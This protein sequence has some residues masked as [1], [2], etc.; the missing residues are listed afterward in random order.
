[1]GLLSIL[2]HLLIIAMQFGMQLQESMFLLSKY[3]FQMSMHRE[4]FRH[5]SVTAPVSAGQIVGL[6]VQGYELGFSSYRKRLS[7]GRE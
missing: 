6:G 7:K 3:I 1:M 4:S 2:E 5:Q